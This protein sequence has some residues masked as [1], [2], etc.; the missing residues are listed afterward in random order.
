MK[1]PGGPLGRTN[2]W[3]IVKNDKKTG[4]FHA[5][6]VLSRDEKYLRDILK[7]FAKLILCG[8]ERLR[9]LPRVPPHRRGKLCRRRISARKRG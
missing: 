5:Y 2:A 3:K 8:D 6:L 7:R 4:L 1:E 9:E